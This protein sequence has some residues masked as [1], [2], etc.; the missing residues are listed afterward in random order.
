MEIKKNILIFSNLI[1]V[2]RSTD[3]NLSGPHIIVATGALMTANNHS[4][5]DSCQGLVK[6]WRLSCMFKSEQHYS[7]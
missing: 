5:L 2:C 3:E 6:S 7:E 1:I 4:A